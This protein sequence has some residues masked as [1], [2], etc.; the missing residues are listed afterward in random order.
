MGVEAWHHIG[1]GIPD[2]FQCTFVDKGVC[3]TTRKEMAQV[4]AK[5]AKQHNEHE[6][7]ELPMLESDSE[8]ENVK[9]AQ[10]KQ[11][12]C[13]LAAS[14]A[15]A[16]INEPGATAVL[17]PGVFRG[18]L[19]LLP[20]G[21]IMHLWW[22][23]RALQKRNGKIVASYTTFRRVFK[24]LRT[25]NVLNFRRRGRHATCTTCEQHKKKL[26]QAKLWPAEREQEMEKYSTHLVEQWLDRQ[27]YDHFQEMSMGCSHALQEGHRWASTMLSTSMLCIAV[28]GMD[29]AKFRVPRKLIITHAFE[30]LLRPLGPRGRVRPCCLRCRPEKRFLG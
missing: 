18:P 28:D 16:A 20:P 1:E 21:K 26:R 15:V 29:Q 27:V 13:I 14:A 6:D 9:D 3:I 8:D 12:R 2:R 11:T 4:K 24:K 23:Y 22:E 7:E 10:E 5:P 30:R 19:R 17:G 25:A